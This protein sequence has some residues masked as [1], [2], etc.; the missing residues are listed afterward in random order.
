MKYRI[1]KDTLGKVKVPQGAYWGVQTQRAVENFPIS[2][3]RLQPV[4]VWAQ[5]AVKEA[6]ARA[7]Q[8]TGKLERKKARA[9]VKACSKIRSGMLQYSRT[10]NMQ[11]GDQFVV[12]VYQA[13]A[14]TS[15]NMNVNEVVANLANELLGAK[16]GSY[17][18]IHPNDHVNMSQSTNDT[19]PSSLYIASFKQV[20]EC[21]LPAM[22]G[23]LLKLVKKTKE[24]KKIKKTG[25]THLRDAVLLSLGDEFGAY[26]D[27]VGYH[28]REIEH[29]S[30]NLLAITLGATAVGSE[31]N[32]GSEYRRQALA[33]IRKITGY[34]FKS[35]SN[36]YFGTQNI[37]A[38]IS[39]SGVLRNYAVSLSKVANDLRLLS[40]GPTSGF[41]EIHL[42][43]SQPG[44]SIMPGK[45]NPSIPEM[46]N[47]VCHQVIGLDQA[48]ISAGQAA[49]LELNVMMPVMAYD[50]L[51]MIEILANASSVFA[52][53]C[54]VDIQANNKKIQYYLERNP[55][56]ATVLAPKLGY[57]KTAE[58]I[59]EAY[60]RD[61]SIKEVILEN[62]ILSEKELDEYI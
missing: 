16:K 7:N 20:K 39:L 52:H 10:E 15:Q 62:G 13:G 30:K 51:H 50:I 57:E 43:P 8:A 54:I 59:K 60:R 34:P 45:V 5:L 4:F 24:F 32:A 18:Y 26:A 33:E 46:V 41:D 19:I 40:S 29:S 2:G 17:S 3:L 27:V 49:Q 38:I 37:E 56:I 11:W 6:A 21:I 42:P 48:I 9:V 14:G 28:V 61:V 58:F 35:N 47:M 31:L 55:V 44:S 1:E 25:R 23:L 36:L 53:R 12:D 22:S